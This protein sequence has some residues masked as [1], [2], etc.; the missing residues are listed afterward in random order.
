M[1]SNT[2][3]PPARRLEILVLCALALTLYA[4]SLFFPVFSC[5]H[6][7]SLLGYEVLLVGPLGLLL[8]DPR[9]LGNVC[10]VALAVFTL[11]LAAFRRPVWAGLTAAFAISSTLWPAQG[12]SGGGA[13]NSALGLA[14]GGYLW[15]A[16]LL[17]LAAANAWLRARP[18]DAD[19]SAN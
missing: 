10:F 8:A 9:W 4:C 7:E 6:Y 11:R 15:I 17:L 13:M 5:E 3:R 16:A 2:P 18:V 1:S 14:L 12:C 19:R